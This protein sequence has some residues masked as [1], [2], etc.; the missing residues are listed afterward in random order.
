MQNSCLHSH[1]RDVIP[2]LQFPTHISGSNTTFRPLTSTPSFFLTREDTV[3]TLMPLSTDRSKVTWSS[4]KQNCL[5]KVKENY[6]LDLWLKKT[7]IH[8]KWNFRNVLKISVMWSAKWFTYCNFRH[9]RW[10]H[11]HPALYPEIPFM[12]KEE[13]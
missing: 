7:F 9:V 6:S 13:N 2:S 5:W 10:Q 3:H 12:V 1:V 4:S 11:L 8:Q